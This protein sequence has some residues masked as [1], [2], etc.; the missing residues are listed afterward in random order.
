VRLIRKK[1]QH[2]TTNRTAGVD[3]PTT[4]LAEDAA[5]ASN[6]C[7]SPASLSC[8][9]KWYTFRSQQLGNTE[10]HLI[11]ATPALVLL[12]TY[13][14]NTGPAVDQPASK[15]TGTKLLPLTVALFSSQTHNLS[16]Y[17]CRYCMTYLNLNKYLYMLVPWLS[18]HPTVPPYM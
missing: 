13:A 9:T 16:W 10:P 18:Q 5:T 11:T 12:A 7:G 1:K 17:S 2:L 14:T 15:R 4:S 3:R 6:R 8:T